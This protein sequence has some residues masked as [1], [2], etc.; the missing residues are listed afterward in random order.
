ML[1]DDTDDIVSAISNVWDNDDALCWEEVDWSDDDD[2]T[3]M[4]DEEFNN[5]G[6]MTKVWYN[7]DGSEID[8]EDY[9]KELLE[10]ELGGKK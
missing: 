7:A 6:D 4:A 10:E 8:I 3:V 1:D 9:I 2:Y 5:K